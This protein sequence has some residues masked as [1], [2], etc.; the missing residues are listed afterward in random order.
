MTGFYKEKKI[1][2]SFFCCFRKQLSNTY[3]NQTLSAD[4]FTEMKLR[5][6]YYNIRSRISF[7]WN[8][9]KILE[10]VFFIFIKFY[11]FLKINLYWFFIDDYNDVIIKL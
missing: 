6:D 10:N 11:N 7:R 4:T 8:K 2:L 9:I 5:N 3:S 1:I